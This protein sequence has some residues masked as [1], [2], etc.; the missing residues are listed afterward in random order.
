MPEV[1]VIKTKNGLATVI[2][3]NG[4]QYSIQHPSHMRSTKNAKAK[5]NSK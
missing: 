3:Y 4:H 2:R 5:E 1:E